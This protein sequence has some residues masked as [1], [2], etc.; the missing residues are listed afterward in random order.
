MQ[1]AEEMAFAGAML[2]GCYGVKRPPADSG[3]VP[4]QD[5]HDQNSQRDG[6]PDSEKE[7]FYRPAR[8]CLGGPDCFDR[9]GEAH[10]PGNTFSKTTACYR[11]FYLTQPFFIHA[12]IVMEDCYAEMT[13]RNVGC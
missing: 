10:D 5:H 9:F 2:S 8:W 4:E 1:F 12:H 11:S 6:H 13:S 7:G 3:T